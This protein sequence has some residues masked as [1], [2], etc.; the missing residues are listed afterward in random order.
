MLYKRESVWSASV[1]AGSVKVV[2]NILRN[3]IVIGLR[4][5][6]AEGIACWVGVP[7]DGVDTTSDIEGTCY[8]ALLLGFVAVSLNGH[9][10]HITQWNPHWHRPPPASNAAPTNTGTCLLVE[11]STSPSHR[12]CHTS[13]TRRRRHS[14]Y[15]VLDVS[16]LYRFELRLILVSSRR[17]PQISI[18][19]GDRTHHRERW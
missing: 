6:G 16:C 17:L 1:V 3:R 7:G 10:R 12:Q 19:E 5:G 8:Q 18:P 13:P 9:S 15:Q 2:P 14:S 11:E 4:E